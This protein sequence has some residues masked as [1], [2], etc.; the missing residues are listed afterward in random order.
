MRQVWKIAVTLLLAAIAFGTAMYLDRHPLNSP[1]EVSVRPAVQT[2]IP[3]EQTEEIPTETTEAFLKDTAWETT[4][5]TETTLPPETEGREER[6]LLTFVGD[7]TFGGSPVNYY[8][9]VGFVKTVGEDYAYPFRNVISYLEADDA[10][11][12]NLEGPLTD[13]GNPMEKKHAFRGPEA[14]VN[15]LTENSIEFASLANNHTN[16][17]GDVGYRNTQK[18]LDQADIPYVERDA[19][20]LMTL[21]GGLKIGVYG[22]VYYQLDAADMKQEI[23]AL[24]DQGAELVIV[25]PHWGNE[26]SYRA[27]EKQKEIGRAAIDA[28]AD[29]VWGSHPHVLQPIEEYNDGV[30]Y[31]SLGNFSFGGNTAPRDL[32]SAIVVQEVIRSPQGAVTLGTREVIPVSISSSER[33]N[34]FQPTPYPEGI[35]AYDRVMEKI[36]GTY[37]GRNLSIE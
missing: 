20:C 4:F 26:G 37:A 6:F 12:I 23:Q 1:S 31:Y 32:D 19:S 8:A 14:F 13:E 16:D 29:I 25:A 3:T 2:T 30:I 24:R 28:G 7:C 35:R 36:Q 21:E 27:T 34:N 11:F 9:D 18:V 22:M 17:Y 33:F 10:T 5:P 15:I